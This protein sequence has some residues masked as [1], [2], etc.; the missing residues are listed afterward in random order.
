[1]K[2]PD[3]LEALIEHFRKYPGVGQKTAER[4]AL[5]TFTQMNTIDVQA[6]SEAL[7]QLHA[8]IKPCQLCGY[9]TERDVC[10]ICQDS[11]RDP[12]QVLVV[13]DAKDVLTFEKAHS[14][15]GLY[16]V[17]GGTLAPSEGKGPEDLNLKN[18]LERLKDQQHQELIIATNLNE[19]GETTALY[20]QHILKDTGISLTRIGYGLPAGGNIAYADTMTL[21]KAL[22]GRKKM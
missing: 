13:E 9:F 10:E 12:S 20:L 4:Y 2:Y 18:L 1:M 22:E 8:A 3:A 17:L 11:T 15:H 7:I 16:H 5:F 6:F 21:M 19:A 14:Y